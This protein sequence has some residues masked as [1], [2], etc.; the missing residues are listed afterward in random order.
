[1]NRIEYKIGEDIVKII[2]STIYENISREDFEGPDPKHI[3]YIKTGLG[4]MKEIDSKI[5]NMAISSGLVVNASELFKPVEEGGIS[6]TSYTIPFLATM[7]ITI[8]TTMDPV[9]ADDIPFVK[10]YKQSSYNYIIS[11][12]DEILLEVIC[13]G[14]LPDFHRE[15][16]KIIR[17]CKLEDKY[18]VSSAFL[19][20]YLMKKL[21][22]LE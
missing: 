17:E 8:D 6:F 3:V 18:E 13:I 5:R 15:L 9:Q 12:N 11:E 2:E 20:K 1:M 16:N 21:K 22:E 14:E 4:G 7:N 19:T 10:G